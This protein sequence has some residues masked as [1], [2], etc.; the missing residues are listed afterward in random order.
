MKL[1]AK[2]ICKYTKNPFLLL[3]ENTWNQRT[4]KKRKKNHCVDDAMQEVLKIKLLDEVQK[5]ACELL[6]LTKRP[7]DLRSRDPD[8]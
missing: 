5:K 7:G 8:D 6:E 3:K 1:W 4:R 2:E